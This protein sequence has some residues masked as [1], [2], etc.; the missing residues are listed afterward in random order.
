MIWS[1]WLNLCT[2]AY[3]SGV[4]S[5]V[6]E[7]WNMKHSLWISWALRIFFSQQI[8]I[9]VFL[10]AIVTH[11]QYIDKPIVYTRSF[12]VPFRPRKRPNVPSDNDSENRNFVKSHEWKDNWILLQNVHLEVWLGPQGQDSQVCPPPCI[13]LCC[14]LEHKLHAMLATKNIILTQK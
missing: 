13:D 4:I 6:S 3:L 14:V 11:H 1:Y 5:P 7:T 10:K 12:F 8:D 2:V 9:S